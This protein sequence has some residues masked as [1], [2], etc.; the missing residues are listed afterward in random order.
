MTHNWCDWYV[1]F[2]PA[3]WSNWVL[4]AFAVVATIVGL[5]TLSKIRT[6]TRAAI[7]ALRIN[8]VAASAAQRSAKVAERTLIDLERPWLFVEL[9][10]FDGFTLSAKREDEVMSVVMRWTIRNYGRMP[11]FVFDGTAR[12][13]IAAKTVPGPPE[14]GGKAFLVTSVPMPPN[15]TQRNA[16]PW[17]IT[18]E[19]YSKLVKDEASLLFFGFIKYRDTLNGDVEHISRWC[20]TLKIPSLVLTGGSSFYWVLEGPAGYETEYT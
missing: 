12:L 2:G 18:T 3:T 14:Y 9:Q 16:S 17:I 11:A 4:A 6:Q 7:V 8:R 13:K 19:E 10:K 20:A 15:K 5:R 1:A